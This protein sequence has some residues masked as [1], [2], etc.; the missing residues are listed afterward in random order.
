MEITT[1][2]LRKIAE[3]QNIETLTGFTSDPD[4]IFMNDPE[5]KGMIKYNPEMNLEQLEM[6]I[7]WCIKSGF[8]IAIQFEQGTKKWGC[9]IFTT[10]NYYSEFG[11]NKSTAFLKSFLQLIETK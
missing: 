6:I 11:T 2:E 1:N 8:D 4:A 3:H 10:E 9:E 7:D 5:T